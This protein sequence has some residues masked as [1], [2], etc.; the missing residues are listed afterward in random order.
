[1][2]HMAG[3]WIEKGAFRLNRTLW[4]A[5]SHRP[6]TAI[7]DKY[8]RKMM[9]NLNPNAGEV[10]FSAVTASR[11]IVEVCKMSLP[12]VRDFLQVSL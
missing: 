1:V 5:T 8:L 10:F 12:A 6:F 11:D 4:L 9:I 3:G 2:K 7:Q